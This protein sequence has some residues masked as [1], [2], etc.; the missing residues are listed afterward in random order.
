VRECLPSISGGQLLQ[1]RIQ[2]GSRAR[3]EPNDQAYDCAGK[4]IQTEV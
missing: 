2:P 1:S 3:N 4:Q